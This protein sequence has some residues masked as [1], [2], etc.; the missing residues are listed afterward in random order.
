MGEMGVLRR[1]PQNRSRERWIQAMSATP[2]DF[3]YSSG[4]GSERT[5][6]T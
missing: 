3:T 4:V 6:G 1:Y 2:C 5:W